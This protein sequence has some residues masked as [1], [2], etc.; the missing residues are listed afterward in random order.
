[1]PVEYSWGCPLEKE[2]CMHQDR[3]MAKA[4]CRLLRVTTCYVINI[5]IQATTNSLF[6]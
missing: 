6:C 2:V 4:I 1:M 5:H 3:L